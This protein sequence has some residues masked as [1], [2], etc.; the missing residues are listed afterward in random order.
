[1]LNIES[2][3]SEAEK[4]N[5]NQKIEKLSEEF[6]IIAEEMRNLDYNN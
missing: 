6:K 3:L 1:M 2:Q 4:N 5:E